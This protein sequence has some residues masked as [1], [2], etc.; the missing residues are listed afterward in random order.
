MRG[1]LRLG[2]QSNAGFIVLSIEK[3]ALTVSTARVSALVGGLL[4]G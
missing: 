2:H 1:S 3:V 4:D